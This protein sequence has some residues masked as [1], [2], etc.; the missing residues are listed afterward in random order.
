MFSA[1]TDMGDEIRNLEPGRN[2]I[3]F[4]NDF[5]GSFSL[6]NYHRQPSTAPDIYIADQ[7]NPL[8]GIQRRLKTANSRF[9]DSHR[10]HKDTADS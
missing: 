6:Q 10:N 9:G 1:L 7:A 2:S 8:I 4:T 3:L 5:K